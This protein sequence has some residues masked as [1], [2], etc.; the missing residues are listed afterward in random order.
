MELIDEIRLSTKGPTMIVLNKNIKYNFNPFGGLSVEEME[1]VINPD[2]HLHEI[3]HHLQTDQPIL[4]EL[5]GKKGRGKTTHLKLLHSRNPQSELFCLDKG[6]NLFGGIISSAAPMIFI[7]SIHHLNLSERSKIY[8]LPKQIVFTTHFTR[9]L[10][11]R[12]SSNKF[13]SYKIKGITLENLKEMIRN[14]VEIAAVEVDQI[15]I[16]EKAIE[17]L[18]V[19]YGDDYRSILRKLYTNFANEK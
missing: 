7:D 19:K 13:V 10:E 12:L 16:N 6:T 4:L 18:M 3:E 2:K 17:Q 9:W 8:K 14:R 1:Q 11:T 5:T 15:E